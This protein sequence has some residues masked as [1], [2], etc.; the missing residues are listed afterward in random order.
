MRRLVIM[1]IVAA[2]TLAAPVV[3]QGSDGA[4]V[5]NFGQ[6]VGDVALGGP[7]TGEATSGFTGA[8]DPFTVVSAPSGVVRENFPPNSLEGIGCPVTP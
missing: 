5:F 1:F 8:L 4:Q 6:C 2:T 3:A 7:G